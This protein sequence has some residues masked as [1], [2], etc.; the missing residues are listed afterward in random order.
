MKKLIYIAITLLILPNLAQAYI[1]P[2]SG[3]AIMAAIMG[4][5]VAVSLFFKTFWYKLKALITGKKK[6][7]VIS[8]HSKESAKQTQQKTNQNSNPQ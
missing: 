6:H 1:D 7:P 2:S 3:S 8:E 5:A 4:A